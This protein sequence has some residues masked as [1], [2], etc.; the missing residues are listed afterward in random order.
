MN[1]LEYG[2]LV[3]RKDQSTVLAANNCCPHKGSRSRWRYLGEEKFLCTNHGNSF[4]L[5]KGLIS[6]CNSDRNSGNLKQYP[7]SIQNTIITIEL[8]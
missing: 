2:V 7:A 6:E 1:I 3:L 4:E 8:G 5:G